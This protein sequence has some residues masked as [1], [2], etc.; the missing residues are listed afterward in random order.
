MSYWKL[1]D[2][3]TYEFRDYTLSQSVCAAVD[4]LF[5]LVNQTDTRSTLQLYVE[6]EVLVL[7][8]NR[9]FNASAD[10]TKRE[11]QAIRLG[12]VKRSIFDLLNDAWDVLAQSI[13]VEK[14]IE[15]SV[16]RDALALPGIPSKP[17]ELRSIFEELESK[18]QPKKEDPLYR[19]AYFMKVSDSGKSWADVC[20]AIGY[21]KEDYKTLSQCVA[22]WAEREGM[23]PIQQPSGSKKRNRNE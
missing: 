21:A 4:R 12:T 18:M 13:N 11:Y 16:L 3:Y 19:D 8:A 1:V 5:D 22:R 2:A 23:P 9:R 20:V 15:P 14:P 10:A 7:Q 17:Y 6:Y